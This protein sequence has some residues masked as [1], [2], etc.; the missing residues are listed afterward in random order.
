M[1]EETVQ[2]GREGIGGVERVDL[3]EGKNEAYRK[4][5]D[6]RSER[7]RSTSENRRRRKENYKE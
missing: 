1:K 4:K 5:Q 6:T 3:K 2:E 7:R